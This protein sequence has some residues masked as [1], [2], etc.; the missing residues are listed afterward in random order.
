MKWNLKKEIKAKR[1]F[2]LTILVSLLCF[3]SV[4]T[5][6]K[7][8]SYTKTISGYVTDI[9]GVGINHARVDLQKKIFTFPPTVYIVKTVYSDSSGYYS[10]TYT[11][12][13][14]FNLKVSKTEY[15]TQ[16]RFILWRD[17]N[18]QT[19]N[20]VLLKETTYYG[21]IYDQTDNNAPI[22]SASVT[23][24]TPVYH[25]VLDKVYTDSNGYYAISCYTG[26]HENVILQ[27]HKD[28]SKLYEETVPTGVNEQKDIYTSLVTKYAV[29]VGI[30]DYKYI[31]DLSLCDEDATDWHN[32][33]VNN[34]SWK[35]ANIKIY[36]DGH[37]NNY[38]KYDGIATEYNVKLALD[39][40]VSVADYND[41]IAFIT[42]GHGGISG[43]SSC[44]C[45]WDA[46]DGENGEDGNLYDTE[47]DSILETT[48]ADKI[49]AF[50]DNCHS[51]GFGPELMNI[52]NSIHI[53]LTTTCTEDGYG[54]DDFDHN[55]GCWTY[56]FLEYSWQNYYE[57][58]VYVCM[59]DIFD[60]AHDNYPY[61]G[62][63]EPQEFDGNPGSW[64]YLV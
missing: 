59:E 7:G 30:S 33:L 38:P 36:G 51:G 25:T 15:I 2:Y 53:Y 21:Y 47:L 39:W 64:F 23:M 52:D 12:S 31:G 9:N 16:T 54:F 50:F 22:V 62:V 63:N 49:F 18:P 61:G 34:L 1:I 4:Q 29:I 17:N 42:A 32:H 56:Y 3:L 43:G 48:D 20:F 40:L 10:L 5:L 8:L 37:T 6:V 45:M 26:S 24:L 27:V 44:L 41:I 57:A 55:N 58:G 46:E 28:Y 14:F 35:S 13:G 60:Y 19:E 11:G